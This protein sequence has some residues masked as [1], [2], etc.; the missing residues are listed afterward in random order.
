MLSLFESTR[1]IKEHKPLA[2][3]NKAAKR[4]SWNIELKGLKICGYI[5]IGQVKLH[6]L[7]MVQVKMNFG[8]S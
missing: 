3:K 6:D 8:Q 7:K 4:W 2:C 1:L 5:L